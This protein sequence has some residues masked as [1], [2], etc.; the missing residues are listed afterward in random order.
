MSSSATPA[1]WPRAFQSPLELLCRAR[2]K[3][4]MG[5]DSGDTCL[6]WMR[7]PAKDALLLRQLRIPKSISCL[8]CIHSLGNIVSISLLLV[9]QSIEVLGDLEPHDTWRGIREVA[10]QFLGVH[11]EVSSGWERQADRGR[12]RG[13]GFQRSTRDKEVAVRHKKSREE[14]TR[15]VGPGQE[16][17]TIHLRL[18]EATNKKCRSPFATSASRASVKACYQGR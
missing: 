18:I 11:G 16:G 5:S 7:W 4:K 2:M 1:F 17:Q 9:C 3:S 15:C 12:Q 10:L 13:E 8:G 6:S 14:S